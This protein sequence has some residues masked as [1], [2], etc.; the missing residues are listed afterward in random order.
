V[1][2]QIRQAA[3]ARQ[4][5]AVAVL[6]ACLARVA[7][8]APTSLVLP[9]II[10]SRVPLCLLVVTVSLT[11]VGKSSASK[12][13]GDLLPGQ[14]GL[15][16]NL[17]IGSGEGLYEVMYEQVSEPT[18]D[19]RKTNKVHKQVHTNA[20][21]YVDEG[22]VL[23]AIHKRADST[24]MANFRQIITGGTL[25][26]TNASPDRRRHIPFGNYAYGIVIGLQAALAGDLL[27]VDEIKAGTPARMVWVP[28]TDPNIPGDEEMLGWPGP[29]DWKRPRPERLIPLADLPWDDPDEGSGA[30]RS[31]RQ[32]R[33]TSFR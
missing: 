22:Q 8:M 17:P 14:D 7:A 25:G 33:S 10:G 30:T 23:S 20:Y 26:N 13:A 2:E 16:D 18:G 6:M 5:S 32:R 31:G 11:G 1:L 12:V 24:L 9:P 19:G 4:C 28:A 21:F 3:H 27:T 15:L 29:I